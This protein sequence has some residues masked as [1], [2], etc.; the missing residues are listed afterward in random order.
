VE[1]NGPNLKLALS[2][3]PNHDDYALLS[4]VLYIQACVAYSRTNE[5]LRVQLAQAPTLVAR[6]LLNRQYVSARSYGQSYQVY[7]CKEIYDFSFKP[8]NKTLGC[9]VEPQLTFS[10]SETNTMLLGYLDPATLIIH[11]RGTPISCNDMPNTPLYILDG[12]KEY[13]PESGALIPKYAP[14]PNFNILPYK[15]SNELN[16]LLLSPSINQVVSLSSW[17]ANSATTLSD[18]VQNFQSH[19]NISTI[20]R[21]FTVVNN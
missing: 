10:L 7:P 17:K 19:E 12:P 4:R 3:L 8:M 1:I 13:N 15:R 14:T 6:S 18:I 21:I 20:I 16:Q 2:T 9:T 11:S 5:L